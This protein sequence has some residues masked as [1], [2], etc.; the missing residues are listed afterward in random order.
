VHLGSPDDGET[1]F[2]E[3]WPE[4]RAVSDESKELYAELGLGRGSVGQLF[5]PR[6]VLAGLR[7]RRH[8]VGRPVG[9]PMMMSGWFLIDRG[10]VVWS[11]VHAHAGEE[12]RYDE[13]LSA[14]RELGEAPAP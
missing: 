7:A 10:R 11:H 14:C 4:A 3:R 5:S 2:G 9:D 8:G 6:V 12:R 1:F 13:L